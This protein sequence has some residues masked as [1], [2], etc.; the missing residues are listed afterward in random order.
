MANHP[1][2]R[3]KA[4]GIKTTNWATNGELPANTQAR[5]PA[6]AA[7]TRARR[8]IVSMRCMV[9]GVWE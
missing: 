2:N 8:R 1:A 5:P 6:P 3:P 9:A 4:V 7:A